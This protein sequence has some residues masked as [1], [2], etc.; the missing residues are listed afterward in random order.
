M[1]DGT[2][3]EIYD[4]WFGE[5]SKYELPYDVRPLLNADNFGENYLYTWPD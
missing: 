4:K 1:Q 3:D 2:Y 5:G